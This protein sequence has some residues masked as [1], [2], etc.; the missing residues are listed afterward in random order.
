MDCGLI[1]PFALF[2][3]AELICF[4]MVKCIPPAKTV[5]LLK[6]LYQR[7][8]DCPGKILTNMSKAGQ[9][10]NTAV[11]EKEKNKTNS[12]RKVAYRD[13]RNESGEPVASGIYFYTIKAGDFTAAKKIVVAK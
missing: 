5:S 11:C 3:R 10:R 13:G 7:D 12:E 1:S 9:A 2:A 8:I 4:R 6:C